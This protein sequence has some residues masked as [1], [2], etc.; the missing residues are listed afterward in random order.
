MYLIPLIFTSSWF[1]FF[2]QNPPCLS[3]A[4]FWCC[5]GCHEHL[6]CK[7]LLGEWSTPWL[8]FA[9]TSHFVQNRREHRGWENR[10]LLFAID[11]VQRMCPRPG[12]KCMARVCW[13]SAS[14]PGNDWCP[15][16]HS[17]WQ[18]ICAWATCRQVPKVLQVQAERYTFKVCPY[19]LF[20]QEKQKQ[21][22]KKGGVMYISKVERT[23][24]TVKFQITVLF[25]TFLVLN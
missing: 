25:F 17:G 6:V 8:F 11:S 12:P 4:V 2:T 5:P 9:C 23:R 19:F 13:G 20:S 15:L 10:R 1:Y 7:V 14:K 22:N 24:N 16:C 3:R 21:T 18:K